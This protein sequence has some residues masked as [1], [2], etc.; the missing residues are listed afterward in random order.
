[1]F[2]GV[3]ECRTAPSMTMWAPKAEPPIA[4]GAAAPRGRHHAAGG[5][6]RVSTPALPAGTPTSPL[7]G[8]VSTGGPQLRC[9]RNRTRWKHREPITPFVSQGWTSTSS[10]GG[11]RAS[12]RALVVAAPALAAPVA[13]AVPPSPPSPPLSRLHVAAPAVA[14]PTSP[15]PSRP[16]FSSS[17]GRHRRRRDQPHRRHLLRRARTPTPAT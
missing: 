5:I 4:H 8:T 17:R 3:P 7:V 9:K 13:A 1:M 2:G 15:P 10:G 16:P 12:R 14:A 6:V 11:A